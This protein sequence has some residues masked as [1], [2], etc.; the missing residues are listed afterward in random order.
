MDL[1][2]KSQ[3]EPVSY[4]TMLHSEQKC[5]I[6]YMVEIYPMLEMGINSKELLTHFDLNLL[7]ATDTLKKTYP[8]ILFVITVSADGMVILEARPSAG[9]VMTKFVCYI[10]IY[11]QDQH[12]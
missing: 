4:P 8:D 11:I 10:Y 6:G 12:F 2:H 1:I 7:T 9:T 3:S 5:E